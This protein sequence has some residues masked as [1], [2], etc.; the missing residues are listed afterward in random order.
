MSAFTPM[1]GAK[2]TL[3]RELHRPDLQP[4]A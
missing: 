2:Q 3:A 1:L 4:P